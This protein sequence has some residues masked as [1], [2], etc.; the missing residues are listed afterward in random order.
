M[1][2]S[3]SQPLV[4]IV[5]TSYNRAHWI[6]KAVESALS[7]DYPNFEIIISDNN[8]TDNTGEVLFKYLSNPRVKYSK[9]DR[10]IGMFGNFKKA[11]ELANGEYI[12]YISSDDYLINNSFVSEAMQLF[13]SHKNIVVV[14]E[15]EQVLD[16]N[17]NKIIAINNCHYFDNETMKGTDVFKLFP[18]IGG[19]SFAGSVM[20]KEKLLATRMYETEGLFKDCE[21]CLKLCL[22]GDVGF[23]DK[24]AYNVLIHGS[25]TSQYLTT[26]NEY[27]QKIVDC[28][29]APY[30]FAKEMAKINESDLEEWRRLC[31]LRDIRSGLKK[32]YK[33]KNNEFDIFLHRVNGQYPQLLKEVRAA[34]KWNVFL[35]LAPLYRRM[36]LS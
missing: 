22:L 8:S 20:N 1:N 23:I 26:S 36:F 17:T 24:M 16:Y 18:K 33:L 27:L 15:K 11:T 2:A 25:N 29:E 10:N 32:L 31:T 14:Y 5:I 7:Q 3:I 34:L 9:N 30:K 19:L 12:T 13:Q 28:T 6:Y 4:S 21:A 35:T